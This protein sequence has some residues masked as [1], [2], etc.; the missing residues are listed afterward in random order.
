MTVSESAIETGAAVTPSRPH[1]ELRAWLGGLLLVVAADLLFWR[2]WPGINAFVFYLA[3][4]AAILFVRGARPLDTRLI[5]GLAVAILGALP[6]VEAFS[7]LGLLSA[8]FGVSVLALAADL[9]LPAALVDLPATLIRFGLVSPFRFV[10]DALATALAL[11]ERGLGRRLVRGLLVWLVPLVCA[12]IFLLLF[13]AANP[14]IESALAAVNLDAIFDQ[15]EIGRV[16]FWGIVICFVW[17]LLRPKLLNPPKLAEVHGPSLPRRETLVF[18]PDAI[19]RALLLFNGLFAIQ[20]ALDIAYLWGGVTLP[21]GMTYASYAHRGAYPLIVTALLAAA[22]VLA[23]MRRDGAAGKSP[24][25]RWLV[26]LFI[27]QNVLLVVSSMLRLDLYVEVYSLTGLRVA[28]A[29]W[30]GLVAAGL[31]LILVRI[32][33]GKSNKWLIAANLASLGLTL[34][35]AAFIDF[36]D[37]IARFNIAHSYEMTGQG[38]RLDTGYLRALGPAVIPALDE[39]LADPNRLPPDVAEVFRD[40]RHSR[41]NFFL[42]RP[43]DWRGWTWRSQRLADH[44]ARQL[45][46]PAADAR[47]GS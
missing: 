36:S 24:L 37:V 45:A 21:D 23:A 11:A 32:A 40:I 39:L 25:I 18:G 15:L 26:Y 7:L 8:T 44:L 6:L 33:L 17:P 20:T 22:F 34:Y 3:I 16:L 5:A 27:A 30:M 2:H 14:L 38:T 29:I 19:L 28:A 43:Q 4:A 46:A 47:T 10:A 41:A 1:G 42:S 31:V 9:K 35:V 13:S 12:A